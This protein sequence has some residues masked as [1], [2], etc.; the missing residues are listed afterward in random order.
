MSQDSSTIGLLLLSLMC[1]LPLVTGCIIGYQFRKRVA[2]L[3]MPGALLPAFI[4]KLLE[5]K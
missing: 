2:K 5:M 1:M 4:R 3:G